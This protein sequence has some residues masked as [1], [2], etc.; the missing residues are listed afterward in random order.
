M[1]RA[2]LA[3]TKNELSTAE[4]RVAEAGENIPA[5]PAPDWSVVRIYLRFLRLIGRMRD[6]LKANM[7][8]TG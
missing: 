8:L 2:E 4:K 5:L 6:L 1:L 3:S 7:K